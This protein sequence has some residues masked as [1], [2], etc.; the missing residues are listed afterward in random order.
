MT[1][2]VFLILTFYMFSLRDNKG[3]LIYI[4][5]LAPLDAPSGKIFVREE[6]ILYH[7]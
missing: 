7:I 3:S 4:R 1:I 6:N 2:V 5:G